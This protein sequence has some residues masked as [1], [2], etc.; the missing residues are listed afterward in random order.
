MLVE[1]ISPHNLSRRDCMS[2]QCF[3]VGDQLHVVI[4]EIV[5]TE[6]CRILH[7]SRWQQVG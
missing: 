6:F 4:T 7:R 2:V 1:T 5:I 3:I